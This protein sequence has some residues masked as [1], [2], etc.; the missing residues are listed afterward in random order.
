[1]ATAE[2]VARYFIHLAAQSEEPSPVT[3]MQ[4][5]KLMYYAQGWSL[6]MRDRPL[7]A[8]RIEAWAHGPVVRELF[9]KFTDFENNPI[10]GEMANVDPQLSNDDRALIESIWL[11]YGRYSAWRLREMTHAEAP[12]VDARGGL[13]EGA[14]SQAPIS[15]E[16]LRAFFWSV[17][18]ARCR[19]TG[20]DAGDLRQ[21]LEDA[22]TGRT[23]SFEEVFGAR[24][25][26]LAR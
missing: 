17:H 12:W 3:H 26:G 2:A 22:R 11:G 18:E 25:R 20:I 13:S 9:P 16:S 21:S 6:A 23:L 5:Q 8:G 4:L 14:P 24:P 10:P 15:L 1:M 19:R 7:F